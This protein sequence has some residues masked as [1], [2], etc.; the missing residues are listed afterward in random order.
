M[1]CT[2][3]WLVVR[4]IGDLVHQLVLV[5]QDAAQ[6]LPV[7]GPA[8]RGQD[9]GPKR[10]RAH[11]RG[12][13]GSAEV[14][15]PLPGRVFHER[16]Q[17]VLQP[18]QQAHRPRCHLSPDGE[19]FLLAVGDEGED[20]PVAVRR[21]VRLNERDRQRQPAG[22]H[23]LPQQRELSLGVGE[24]GDHLHDA[25]PGLAYRAG[26]GDQLILA[27]AVRRRQ[28]AVDALVVERAR[29]SEAERARRHRFAGQ[30]RDLRRLVRLLP[31]PVP[32]PCC[33]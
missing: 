12:L 3:V 11:Q 23:G 24:I 30:P 13:G 22:P 2:A 1:V 14:R 4:R 8:L 21:Q 5:D 7:L 26:D 9:L 28:L 10:R 25:A 32:R 18:E 6:P 15:D 17:R 29:G 16:V 33:P 19:A 31:A 27:G 20:L